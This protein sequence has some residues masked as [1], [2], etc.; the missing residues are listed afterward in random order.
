MF[1][2]GGGQLG[3]LAGK[4]TLVTAVLGQIKKVADQILGELSKASPY[5]A[6]VMRIFERAWMY[7]L[8]PFGDFLGNILK[9]LAMALL[10][11]SV[12]WMKGSRTPGGQAVVG[13]IT[14]AVGGAMIG[15]VAGSI[16]PGVGTAIGAG[17]GAGVGA[18]IGVLS[19]VDWKA[20]GE[21]I[22]AFTGWIT[23]GL[24]YFL[25]NPVQVIKDIGAGIV[26][27]VTD[28]AGAIGGAWENFTGWLGENLPKIGEWL[29]QKLGEG[30]RKIA[31]YIMNF[32][33]WL[34]N[35]ITSV[36]KA[37]LETLT[38]IGKWFWNTIT[39][40]VKDPL[41]TLAGFGKWLWDVIIGA[42][43]HVTTALSGFGTWIY[44]VLKAALKHVASS[45]SGFG[46]WLY[47]TI[48]NAIKGIGGGIAGFAGGVISGILGG[49]QSGTNF[50]PET[51][52][53][54]LHRGESVV[55]ST[56]TGNT[57]RTIILRPTFNIRADR[58]NNDIDADALMRRAGRQVEIDLRRRG[59]V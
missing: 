27:G 58:I 39:N 6:G 18:L 10:K 48:K 30:L 17:V 19:T 36:A 56:R 14:G 23:D 15:A 21:N 25:N 16:V 24:A 35:K 45:L 59:L 29:G 8:K 38:G 20:L 57:S 26:K 47:S 28:F 50:I 4:M 31:E 51:G 43:T 41:G 11:L 5:L 9:P 34:W 52:M 55:P 32:G 1:G 2:G 40:F 46:S 22:S 7:T 13:G 53:Y 54:M 12:E 49:H 37:A 44:D 3:N 33:G 42:L